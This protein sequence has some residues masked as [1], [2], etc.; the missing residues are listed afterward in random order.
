MM[1]AMHVWSD[2]EE[3]QLQINIYG[4]TNITVIKHGRNIEENLEDKN[5]QGWRSN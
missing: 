3:A 2:H 5:G 4:E 1:D